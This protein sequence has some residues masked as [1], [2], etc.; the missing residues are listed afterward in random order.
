MGQLGSK[1]RVRELGGYDCG[2]EEACSQDVTISFAMSKHLWGR[3][4]SGGRGGR[5]LQF[6]FF[7]GLVSVAFHRRRSHGGTR[8]N[9]IIPTTVPGSCQP[10]Q[11]REGLDFTPPPQGW[12]RGVRRSSGRKYQRKTFIIQAVCGQQV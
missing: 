1:S 11:S 10:A 4:I 8:A 5:L 7:F 6:F 3:E 9:L 12:G 2:Q